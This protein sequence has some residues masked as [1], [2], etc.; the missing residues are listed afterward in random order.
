MQHT[1]CVHSDNATMNLAI[2]F[3]TALAIAVDN[4]RGDF[5]PFV[6]TEFACSM[7]KSKL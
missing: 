5:A 6:P 2:A 4:V 7:G 1:T 3:L